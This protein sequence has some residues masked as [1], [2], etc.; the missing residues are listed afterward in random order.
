MQPALAQVAPGDTVTWTN[1]DIVPHTVTAGG[2]AWDSGTIEGGKTWS[3]VVT[4]ADTGGYVCRFHA[5][6]AG[7]FAQR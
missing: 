4:A 1:R 2:G 3:H 6:M 5:G 7:R